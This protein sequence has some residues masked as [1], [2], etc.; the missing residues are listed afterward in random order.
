MK[1]WRE[2]VSKE[3]SHSP[4]L[5]IVYILFFVDITQ[6][7]EVKIQVFTHNY[8]I[9]KVSVKVFGAL[10]M[11]TIREASIIFCSNVIDFGRNSKYHCVC[12]N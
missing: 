12:L 4:P 6:K 10:E 5:L 1:C 9:Q 2:D 3:S 8:T 7:T 11:T